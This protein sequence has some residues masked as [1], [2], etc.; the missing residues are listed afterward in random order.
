MQT[1]KL[2][3]RIQPSF[4]REILSAAADEGV[5]SLAGGLPAS[6]SFPLSLIMEKVAAL[7]NNPALFQYGETI[8][9]R[10]LLSYLEAYYKVDANHRMMVC[11]GSQQGLDIIARA[12]LNPGDGVAMEA[13]CYPGAMQVFAM[14]GGLIHSVQQ[15]ATG[16]DLSA[17]EAIFASG[18]V[19]MFYAVPDFHNPT[20]VCWTLDVR[21]RVA[22]LCQQY[23]VGLVEDAPYRELRFAGQ[24][25]PMVSSF[26][27]E[28]SLVL[29]SFSKISTPGMRLGVL[30]APEEWLSPLVKVKQASDLHSSLPMQALLLDLLSNPAFPAHIQQLRHLYA[31]RYQA[32]ASALSTTLGERFKFEPVQ[33]GMFVWLKVPNSDPLALSKAALS[34]G[35]AVVPSNAFYHDE[36]SLEAALRL[37]FS[38]ECPDTLREAVRRLAGILR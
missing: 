5:I 33:G 29:R 36:T 13:P 30:S 14:T 15:K 18:K 20:G 34:K 10:P 2:L 31:E 27:P 3:R 11:S 21:K 28:R 32:L 23:E 22:A 26:C 1:A 7:S 6:D 25:L 8:G 19:K 24:E 9:Y 12:F 37:N 16:P 4:I 17:L 35:V 38:H